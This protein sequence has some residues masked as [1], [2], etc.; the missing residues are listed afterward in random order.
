MD[1]TGRES[2]LHVKQQPLTLHAGHQ[3]WSDTDV[4]QPPVGLHP[5]LV[6]GA[7]SAVLGGGGVHPE[8]PPM[9]V[10]QVL[11]ELVE[12][13]PA[14]LASSSSVSTRTTCLF[15]TN[16]PLPGFFEDIFNSFYC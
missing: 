8:T 7:Q 16:L 10:T 12:A 15:T 13:P 3:H 5:P 2:P 6:G 1:A 14:T 11:P 4:M 9:H